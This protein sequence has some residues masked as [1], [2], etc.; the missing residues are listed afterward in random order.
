[1]DRIQQAEKERLYRQLK[2]NRSGLV[3]RILDQFKAE[4]KPSPGCSS[5]PIP[6]YGKR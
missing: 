6:V 4:A 2:A 3:R 5:E 1:M